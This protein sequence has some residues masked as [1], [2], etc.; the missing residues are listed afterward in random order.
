MPARDYARIPLIESSHATYDFDIFAVCESFLNK[1]IPNED[2]FISGFSGEPFRPD[3]PENIRN[4]G[5]CLFFKEHLAIKE[6]N[7]LE[8]I[9]ETIVPEIKYNRKTN[10]FTVLLSPEFFY[11]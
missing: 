6:R 9:P 5:V 10:Y 4:G 2:I 1:D 11:G 3:K 8:L 7:D